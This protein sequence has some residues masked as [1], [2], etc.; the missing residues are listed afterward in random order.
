M[1]LSGLLRRRR[2]FFHL[3]HRVG[4]RL[5]HQN[6]HPGLKAVKRL[7]MVRQIGRENENRVQFH[8]FQH[9]ADQRKGPVDVELLRRVL[10]ALWT[11]IS[12]RGELDVLQLCQGSGQA[13]P[14]MSYTGNTNANFHGKSPYAA[15]SAR[16]GSTCAD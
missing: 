5:L 10:Q 12:Q 14:S 16:W 3:R 7:R 4:G 6:M 8:A 2:H 9:L 11:Q 15:I 1:M 13:Q